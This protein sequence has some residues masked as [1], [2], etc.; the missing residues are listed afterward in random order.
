MYLH[1]CVHVFIYICIYIKISF[2]MFI[3][4]QFLFP[5]NKLKHGKCEER[6]SV[7]GWSAY[8]KSIRKKKRQF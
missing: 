7:L 3:S 5:N 4:V 2:S 1:V 6:I 8:S